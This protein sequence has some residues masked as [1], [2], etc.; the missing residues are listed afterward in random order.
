MNIIFYYGSGSTFAWKVWL[1]LEYKQIPYE[2]R[3]LSFDK[4]ETRTP[5]F[6]GLNPRG[7]VPTIKDGHFALYESSPIVEYLEEKY[8]TPSLLPGNAM[9]RAT[10][11]RIAAEVDNGFYPAFSRLMSGTLHTVAK[12]RDPARIALAQEE[13]SVE[14]GRFE[15]LFLGNSDY[16]AWELSLADFTLYPLI[17]GLGRLHERAPEFSVSHQIGPK[18]AAWAK[19]IEAMPF[20]EKTRP[21][22]WKA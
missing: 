4:K 9:K 17:A 8:P 10:A 1:T 19:R 5:A 12:E 6:L 13:V 15:Q 2:L 21:P 3:V 20:V 18:V 14:L 11:R 16:L 7:K 22:H